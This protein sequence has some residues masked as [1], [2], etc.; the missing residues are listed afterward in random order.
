MI[1][2]REPNSSLKQPQKRGSSSEGVEKLE[3]AVTLSIWVIRRRGDHFWNRLDKPDRLVLFVCNS[4]KNAQLK[5][6]AC[7][8]FGAKLPQKTGQRPRPHPKHSVM[9][10]SENTI[11][12]PILNVSL[13]L[14]DFNVYRRSFQHLASLEYRLI[15]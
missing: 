15:E 11:I 7:R 9:F 2:F 5:T 1:L 14:N 13:T 12:E 4:E 3:S 8:N 10:H 6:L